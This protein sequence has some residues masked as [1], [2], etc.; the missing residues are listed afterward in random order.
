MGLALA[1]FPAK[2]MDAVRLTGL[3]AGLLIGA[4]AYAPVPFSA[5]AHLFVPCRWPTTTSRL[6]WGVRVEPM[7]ARCA[8]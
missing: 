7:A 5:A 6:A 8:K 1:G 4:S 2:L 3:M